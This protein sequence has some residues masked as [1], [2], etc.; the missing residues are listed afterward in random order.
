MRT[1]GEAQACLPAKKGRMTSLQGWTGADSVGQWQ[2]V[3]DRG[4]PW[5]TVLDSVG[6]W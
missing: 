1:L 6:P 5:Q 2:T 4:R 3:V